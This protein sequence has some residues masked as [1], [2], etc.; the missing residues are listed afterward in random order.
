[1]VRVL[2]VLSFSSGQNRFEFV[3]SSFI[4]RPKSKSIGIHHYLN[5]AEA[6]SL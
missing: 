1:M 6:K 3:S 5:I 4:S 2:F